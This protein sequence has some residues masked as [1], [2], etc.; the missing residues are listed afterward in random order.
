MSPPATSVISFAD[1][2]SSS[3]LLHCTPRCIYVPSPAFSSTECISE[4]TSF[5]KIGSHARDSTPTW[6]RF[7]TRLKVSHMT[8]SGR[9]VGTSRMDSLWFRQ[10]GLSARPGCQV[11]DSC[12]KFHR[13]SSTAALQEHIMVKTF[14]SVRILRHLTTTSACPQRR[15]T[16]LLKRNFGPVSVL[17]ISP[18]PR[19]VI[20][21]SIIFVRSNKT[22]RRIFYAPQPRMLCK[23][24]I[25]VWRTSEAETIS[26]EYRRSAL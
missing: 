3:R 11:R 10:H 23:G 4:Q 16:E 20:R 12:R 22:F 21:L 6:S 25:G 24:K 9:L 15:I 14:N 8:N 17:S 26:P 19:G 18:I 13:I 7:R 5:G 1:L 2:C